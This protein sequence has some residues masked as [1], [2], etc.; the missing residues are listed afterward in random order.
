MSL[1]LVYLVTHPI[2]YQAPLLRRIAADPDIDLTVLF[3][4]DFSVRAHVD[5]GFGQKVEYD[6]PL[7]DGYQSRF[8]PLRGM[9]L[10]AGSDPDFWRPW[11]AGPNRALSEIK[12]DALWVH[13]Y[14]RATNLEAMLLA[15][16]R[17]IPVLLRDEATP[18]SAARSLPKRIAKQVL[19]R[20]I[21]KLVSA[22]LTIGSLNQAFWRGYGVA[23]AKLFDMPYAV[24]NSFFQS[25]IA[26]ASAAIEAVR[27]EH[28]L[29]PG[30][31]VVLF[32]G[33]LIDRKRPMD[34]LEAYAKVAADPA[35]RAPYLLI[36]GSGPLTPALEARAK[37]LEGVRLLG[38]QNQ[39]QLAAL[40]GLTD[41]F[42][43]PSERESWGLVVNEAMNAGVAVIASDRIG[44]A[45][46]LVKAGVNGF[47][48]PVGDIDALSVCL[49]TVLTDPQR[50][51]AMGAASRALIDRWGFDEDIAGLKAALEYVRRR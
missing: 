13:G 19:L 41:L 12:P 29:A 22:Y 15:R 46:D 7:L 25:R 42:V 16:L 49:R 45:A 40:Y 35:L 5:A 33:K 43:L 2:Q 32:V 48:Y 27:A 10:P 8:L 9:P 39:T 14:H 51:A 50:L 26:S 21:D 34:L 4:S 38:F 11:S 44:A 24:D 1:R 28:R 36:A 31:P 47:T 23:D 3:G 37:D 18:I 20:S 30:R 6:V 17:G